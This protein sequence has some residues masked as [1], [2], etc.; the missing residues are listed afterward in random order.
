MKP[1][2]HNSPEAR[3][4]QSELWTIRKTS[5]SAEEYLALVDRYADAVLAFKIAIENK[6]FAGLQSA[7]HS[8]HEIT[9]QTEE[10]NKGVMHA[11]HF[12]LAKGVQVITVV[13]AEG[14]S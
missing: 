5:W 7:Y 10:L 6:D 12:H 9:R 14:K 3:L 1:G 4:R 13:S 8:L 11:L 2:H